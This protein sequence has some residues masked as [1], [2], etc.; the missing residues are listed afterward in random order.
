LKLIATTTK[1]PN[2]GKKSKTKTW[3]LIAELKAST[4]KN[5][6]S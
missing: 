3:K 4:T 1:R 2:S 5:K 6:L